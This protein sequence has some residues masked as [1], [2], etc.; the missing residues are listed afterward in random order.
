MADN[1]LPS[2]APPRGLH[3]RALI[4]IAAPLSFSQ[5]SEMAMNVTDTVLLGGLGATALAV[6]GMTTNLFFCT[7]ITFQAALGGASILIARARGRAYSAGRDL[8]DLSG[9]VTSGVVLALLLC[10]PVLAILLPVGP[11]LSFFDEP[12]FIV[13]Q[14][15]RFMHL[16]LWALVP[17]LVIIGLLRIVLP[18]FGAERL[19]LWTMPGMAVLNGVLNASLIHGHFGLPALGLWGSASATIVTG[20]SVALLL[21]VLAKRQAHLRPHLRLTR[22]DPAAIREMLRLGLPMMGATGAELLAFQMTGLHAG[23]LGAVASA[24]HQ[25]ALSVTSTAFMISL[26]LSQAVN[27]RVAYWLGAGRPGAATRSVLGAIL[28]VLCWT[29]FTAFILLAYPEQIARLYVDPA[30]HDASAVIPLA[31]TLLRIAGLFQILDGVQCVCSGALRGCH[32]TFMPMVFM[33]A[34]YVPVAIF[35]GDWLAFHRGLGAV[36]LWVGLAS[37]LGLLS[38]ILSVRLFLILRRENRSAVAA[39]VFA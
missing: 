22:P 24:S 9:I 5:L 11:L 29:S 19:L 10:L 33:I 21:L 34:T 8:E 30:S 12:A 39:P 26:A 25:I 28:L 7:F 2:E 23:A 3:L 36:G 27:I 31:A 37:G 32:D 17:N 14:G 20:W 38:L 16:L 15:S 35:G 6:G 4:R 13:S 18:A 1:S